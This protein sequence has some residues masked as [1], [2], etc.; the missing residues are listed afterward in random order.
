MARRLDRLWPSGGLWRHPDFLKLW[1]GQTISQVGSQVSALALPLA[2]VLVLDASAFEVALLGTIEFLPFL[3][4][5]LPAGV[6]VDR[7]R[8]R[9]ILIVTDVGRGLFLAS[10]PVAYLFDALT[11]GQLYVVGFLVGICTVF[12][13]VSYQSYLPSLVR[14]D[15]LVEGNSLLEVSRN[16]AQIGGPGLA[17]LLVGAITAP[18]AILLDAFSFL[19]SAGLIAAIRGEEDAPATTEKPSMRREL[20]EG[21]EYLVRHRYWRPISITTAGSNFFW[22]MSW[23]ILI[24]YSVRELD[25]SPAVIGLMFSLGS[26]GG[27]LGAFVGKPVSARFGVGPTIV[28]SAVL[29][30]PA[31]MLV[32]LAPQSFPVPL[33]VASLVLAGAGAVL[34][35]ISAISL[36]QTLTPDRLLGRLNASRRF[37][38]WGTIPLG[39]LAGGTLASVVGLHPTLWVGAIGASVC[40]IPVA[41]SPLRHIH[42]MPTDSEPDPSVPLGPPGTPASASADA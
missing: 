42:D 23:S 15:R 31:L 20:R 32:P 14:K 16:A 30:G 2:A 33:I 3:L 34:Y 25:L 18:Y 4:F 24:V 22:T 40:F 39:S 1:S 19:G 11:I 5:A 36:M 35:N 28:A 41:V 13:D 21:L 12:F 27:L 26:V 17:G 37:I 6:W 9:P 8:R 10:I 29:F 38:V 7:M